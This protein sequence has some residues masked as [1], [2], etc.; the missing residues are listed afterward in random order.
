MANVAA[1]LIRSVARTN[2]GESLGGEGDLARD[3]LV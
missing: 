2:V 3:M 1:L